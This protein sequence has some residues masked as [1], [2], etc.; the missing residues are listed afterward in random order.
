MLI[1]PDLN[2]L[3]YTNYKELIEAY[4]DEKEALLCNNEGLFRIILINHNGPKPYIKP[5]ADFS[6]KENGIEIIS[7][8]GTDEI[9]KKDF[10]EFLVEHYEKQESYLT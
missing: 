6:I 5:S 3:E 10:L 4:V 8:N 9:I 1:Q 7:C 2:K